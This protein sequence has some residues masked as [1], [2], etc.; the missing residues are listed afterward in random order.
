MNQPEFSS[1]GDQLALL[2]VSALLQSYGLESS[3]AKVRG[4][5]M[6]YDQRIW[7]QELIT[8]YSSAELLQNKL[9]VTI[10]LKYNTGIFGGVSIT[11]I[12]TR[13]TIAKIYLDL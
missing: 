5:K 4:Q 13:L 8:L 2:P 12:E 10:S 11:A 3:T 6:D 1:V 7:R 9:C